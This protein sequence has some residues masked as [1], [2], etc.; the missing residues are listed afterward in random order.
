LKTTFNLIDGKL[1]NDELIFTTN[2][3]KEIDLDDVFELENST[4]TYSKASHFKHAEKFQDVSRK[5]S[6]TKLIF[7]KD[8]NLLLI[9]V[10]FLYW[11]EEY[12]EIAYFFRQYYPKENKSI[13]FTQLLGKA[14]ICLLF[15]NL[16]FVDENN[17]VFFGCY[18]ETNKIKKQNL[19]VSTNGE[20]KIY[21]M[22]LPKE[23]SEYK[24]FDKYY[25]SI[26]IVDLPKKTIIQDTRDYLYLMSIYVKFKRTHVYGKYQTITGIN[27]K[28]FD[29][30]SMK[31]MLE[32]N[33]EFN[34]DL[35]VKEKFEEGIFVHFLNSCIDQEGNLFLIIDNTYE[36]MIGSSYTSGRD[37]YGMGGTTTTS[38]SPFYFFTTIWLL[39]FDSKLS[40][41]WLKKVV[42]RDCFDQNTDFFLIDDFEGISRDNFAYYSLIGNNISIRYLNKGKEIPAGIYQKTFSTVDGKEISTST[43]FSVPE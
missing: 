20:T 35:A 21:S 19:F 37:K 8:N 31:I 1:L 15:N 9:P 39:N 4:K 38:S 22:D 12:D 26:S 14:D 25:D 30:N 41:N 18:T 34:K 17:K 33:I 32:N 2:T 11:G 10:K 27:I 40:L 28:K 36:L 23:V 24:Y 16:P 29:K 7:D 3:E 42:D 6:L 5:K 43:I 13:D